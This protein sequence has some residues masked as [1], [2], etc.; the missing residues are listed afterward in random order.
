M[1]HVIDN[2]KDE[3]IFDYTYKIR[4]AFISL[5]PALALPSSHSKEGMSRKHKNTV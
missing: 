4:R 2:H 3:K 5:P 1:I